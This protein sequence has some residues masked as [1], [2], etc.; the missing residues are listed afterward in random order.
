M[1]HRLDAQMYRTEPH[2][3]TARTPRPLAYS[4][5]FVFVSL[6]I[7]FVLLCRNSADL[8]SSDIDAPGPLSPPSDLLSSSPL[9]DPFPPSAADSPAPSTDLPEALR[10]QDADSAAFDIFALAFQPP[11]RDGVRTLPRVD[12][13]HLAKLDALAL[14]LDPHDTSNPLYS[15]PADNSD[16][17]YADTVDTPHFSDT[18]KLQWPPTVTALPAPPVQRRPTDLTLCGA[19]RCRFLLPLRISEPEARARHHV[20]QL[21]RLAHALNRTLVLPNVGK[22]RLGACFRWPLGRYY[23]IDSLDVDLHTPGADDHEGY[24]AD[25]GLDGLFDDTSTVRAV[26]LDAFQQWT[27]GR[28]SNPPS[29]QI[30]WLSARQDG[31]LEHADIYSGPSLVA[32]MLTS[33]IDEVASRLPGCLDTKFALALEAYTPVFVRPSRKALKTGTAGAAVARALLDDQLALAWQNTDA[34]NNTGT[35]LQPADVLVV[36]WDLRVPLFPSPLELEYSAALTAAAR[37]MAPPAPYVAVDWRMDNLAADAVGDCARSLVG[38]LS[39]ALLVHEDIHDVWLGLD[40]PLGLGKVEELDA[41]ALQALQERGVREQ[42]V[43]GA[44]FVTRAF[45]SGGELDGWE[46]RGYEEF[47]NAGL[48]METLQDGGVRDIINRL[49]GEGAAL[50]VASGESCGKPSASTQSLMENR[51]TAFSE[52]SG[53]SVLRNDVLHFE[54]S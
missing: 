45:R 47:D 8:T 10:I 15:A 54:R 13:T 2:M 7:F 37:A 46:V 39:G 49:I 52:S 11:N 3:Q 16:H 19:T 21:A 44:R 51:K 43:D 17:L 28:G 50:F 40:V 6:S 31:A 9:S 25:D 33:G 48:S 34:E 22:G 23:D 20:A 42:H 53:P 14:L 26:S 32:G 35:A 18:P 30:A 41:S 29:A 38:A 12:R 5:V 27:R 1:P 4:S 24:D 36:N